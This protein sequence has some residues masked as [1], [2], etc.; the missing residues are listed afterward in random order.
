MTTLSLT[1]VGSLNRKSSVALSTDHLFALVL[2][3]ES[4]KGGL[5]LNATET[6]TSES[7]N[8]MESGLLL[9]VVV[10]QSSSV[11]ELLASENESLLIGGD[12]LLI[13]NLGS[14]I[15]SRKLDIDFDRCFLSLT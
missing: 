1:A 4:G 13:L 6:T 12:T 11:F 9:N 8:Q 5:D 10:R 15:K 3:G 2:S 7:Q 14:I